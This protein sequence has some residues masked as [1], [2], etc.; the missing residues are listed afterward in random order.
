MKNVGHVATRGFSWLSVSNHFPC[1]A[2][3]T[4]V[5][6]SGPG[7]RLQVPVLAR[8]GGA[9]LQV[10]KLDFCVNRENFKILTL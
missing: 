10:R 1:T 3:P 6:E 2:R 4:H 8:P 9:R 5:S 7:A